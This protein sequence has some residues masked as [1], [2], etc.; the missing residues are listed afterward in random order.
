[1]QHNM[2]SLV[3][4][5][6]QLC[7]RTVGEARTEAEGPYRSGA[8]HGPVRKQ[9]E[10]LCMQMSSLSYVSIVFA[11]HTL[12]PFPRS[13]LQLQQEQ[14]IAS[15]IVCH[16]PSRISACSC[17]VACEPRRSEKPRHFETRDVLF[18]ALSTER[19]RCPC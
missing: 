10:S 5:H 1:M 18:A 15:M 19:L 13:P 14:E 8:S 7:S 12:P 6:L 17:C 11:S 9:S 16:W 4:F 3:V 2:F